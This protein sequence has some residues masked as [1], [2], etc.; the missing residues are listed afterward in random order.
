VDALQW[1]GDRAATR[2]A[3]LAAIAPTARTED[4]SAVL[5]EMLRRR[6]RRRLYQRDWH[7]R[8]RAEAAV[9][10]PRQQSANMLPIQGPGRITRMEVDDVLAKVG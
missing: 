7:R 2:L 5:V 6:E 9:P 3:E 4:Q 10:S 1:L 8:Q